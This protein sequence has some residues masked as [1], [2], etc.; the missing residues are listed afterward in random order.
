MFDHTYIHYKI[1]LNILYVKAQYEAFN[2]I[3]LK[4]HGAFGAISR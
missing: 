1:M 3:P 4:F 2:K